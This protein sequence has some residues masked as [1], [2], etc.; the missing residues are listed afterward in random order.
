MFSRT[1][2]AALVAS[3]A[4]II[5]KELRKAAR[6]V[7]AAGV[8]IAAVL[9]PG[10]AMAD[11]T[12]YGLTLSSLAGTQFGSIDPITG[13]FT[14][15]STVDLS[16]AHYAPVYDPTRNVFYYTEDPT[17]SDGTFSG[18]VNTIDASTGAVTS[19][20][21]PRNVLGLGF[22]TTNGTLYGL[23]LSS[24][25]GTQFGSIDP[26]TGNFTPIS[27]VDLSLAHY[28]PVYDPTRNV[29]YY[30]EDPTSSDGTFSGTVNTIDASTGAVTSFGVPRNV[31]G[32]GF[33]T[34]NGTLYGLTLSS[35]AGTQ[36][37]SIDPITGNFTP[38]S[39]VDLSLAHYAPVYD[40]TRNVFYYTEDPTSS[41]GTFSGTVNTIDAS[42]GAVT[43]F[44]VPRNVL[45]LGVAADGA[46]AVPE[47][48]SLTLLSAALLGFGVAYRRR[49]TTPI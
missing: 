25:A 33:N 36:F 42:T 23:T 41:D 21:V 35:L 46:V 29:F 20:G 40:P 48:A 43:S 37:G 31:L 13:N 47:P 18:T 30:T 22:N 6:S 24:L 26:I 14:P 11:P 32:L 49:R 1:L 44:G 15:I 8:L 16:L 17:S 9:N 38:I 39:T 5:F 34:T 4:M 12:L 19:F 10:A 28:A 3:A 45:G 2:N 7:G 27:T